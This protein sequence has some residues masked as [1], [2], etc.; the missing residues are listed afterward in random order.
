MNGS[1][2]TVVRTARSEAEA[3][4]V[5]EALLSAGFHPADLDASSHY[6][7]AEEEAAF[8]VEVPAGEADAARA[9]L[10]THVDPESEA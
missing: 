6:S 7:F 1:A 10:K 3:E 9:F 4:R 5:V 8:P 2:F